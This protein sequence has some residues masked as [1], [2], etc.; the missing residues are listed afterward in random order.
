MECTKFLVIHSQGLFVV[1]FGLV[2]I[3]SEATHFSHRHKCRHIG[4][5]N[6]E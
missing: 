3:T 4:V 6:C 5:V 2:H 1:L